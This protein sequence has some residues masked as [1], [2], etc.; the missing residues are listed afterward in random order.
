M[1]KITL[2]VNEV[3]NLL[4]ERMKLN[5]R[6]LYYMEAESF[7]FEIFDLIQID[8]K[9]HEYVVSNQN[10]TTVVVE[11]KARYVDADSVWFFD[12]RDFFSGTK[13][14]WEPSGTYCISVYHEYNNYCIQAIQVDYET[15]L[16]DR[17]GRYYTVRVGAWDD[18]C[19]QSFCINEGYDF[20]RLVD[21]VSLDAIELQETLLVQIEE[22]YQECRNIGWNVDKNSLSKLVRVI[23]G[24]VPDKEEQFA[25]TISNI[26]EGA[27]SVSYAGYYAPSWSKISGKRFIRLRY[28]WKGTFFYIRIDELTALKENEMVST[29]PSIECNGKLYAY[30]MLINNKIACN[31][32]IDSWM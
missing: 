30:G 21:K 32:G 18:E 27:L 4:F 23:V 13:N 17:D 11:D 31:Q 20:V 1:G 12:N 15:S 22:F 25:Y 19:I 28:V 3:H 14:E 8:N 10:L 29:S 2:T 26:T 5:D 6:H 16:W 9:F 7:F 24:L